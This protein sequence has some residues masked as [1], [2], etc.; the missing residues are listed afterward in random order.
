VANEPAPNLNKEG[1]LSRRMSK[2]DS[3]QVIKRLHIARSVNF[4]AQGTDL[5]EDRSTAAMQTLW[6][7]L[8]RNRGFNE[9]NFANE[10]SDSIRRH[11]GIDCLD[12]S[13]FMRQ[14]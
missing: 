3:K 8:A 9:P 10:C 11:S 13:I 7:I 14:Q 6:H 12:L 4:E 5:H 2:R 1:A